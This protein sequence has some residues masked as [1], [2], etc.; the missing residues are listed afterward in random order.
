MIS[1]DRGRAGQSIAEFAIVLPIA[2]AM[3]VGL[4][5]VGRVIWAAD[6]AAHAASEAA[7]FAIVRGS[8]TLTGCPVGPPALTISIPPAS[9]DCPHPSPSKQAVVDRALEEAATSGGA[10]TA[11]VCYGAGCVADTDGAGADNSRGNLLTVTVS[12]DLD[13]LS[14]A[15]LAPLLGRSTFE[16]SEK[17]TMKVNN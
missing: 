17:A 14:T 3:L 2:M 9:A 1:S 6:V 13:L 16:V 15:V 10:V 12:T 8:T 7:R 4:F 11:Q 5:D